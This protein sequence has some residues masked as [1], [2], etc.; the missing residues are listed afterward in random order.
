MLGH[1]LGGRLAMPA[2]GRCL[3]PV[4]TPPVS[5][6]AALQAGLD[7]LG[8]VELRNALSARF[9]LELPA[10]AVFDYPSVAALAGFIARQLAAAGRQ[11]GIAAVEGG[12]LALASDSETELA[13]TTQPFSGTTLQPADLTTDLR[14]IGCLYPGASPSPQAATSSAGAGTEW[15]CS[16]TS[17]SLCAACMRPC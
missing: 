7:S 13:L 16:G 6:C 2:T 8:S 9:E 17:M 3:A 14:G 15:V 10:T 1:G 4:L 5:C 12:K 11:P